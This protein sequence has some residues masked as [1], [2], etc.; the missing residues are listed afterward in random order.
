[1]TDGGPP[2][3]ERRVET[4]VYRM[5]SV[6]ERRVSHGDV[7]SIV[8]DNGD[9]LE[10]D[11]LIG[12]D[13]LLRPIPVRGAQLGRLRLPLVLVHSI[14]L[15]ELGC[16]LL[17]DLLDIEARLVIGKELDGTSRTSNNVTYGLCHV[18]NSTEPCVQ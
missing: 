14:H 13:R 6:G 7:L 15:R 1:M 9:R 10:S 16:M 4:G 3:V 8:V 5:E 2:L 18:G 11:D 12:W 17:Q